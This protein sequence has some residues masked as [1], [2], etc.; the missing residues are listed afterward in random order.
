MDIND[1][2][3]NETILDELE[4]FIYVAD[5][6]TYEM[7]YMNKA[8]MDE[9]SC[10][11]YRG[12]KC[13]EV[14]HG[15]G[16]P[17][18]F[19]NS[20]RLI[21]GE[22]FSW[23]NYNATVGRT[24]QLQDK[25]IDYDGHHARMEI[26]I[27]V[28]RRIDENMKLKTV[29]ETEKLLTRMIQT[30]NRH[31][32]MD[33]RLDAMIREIGEYFN[34]DRSY[35]FDAV[36]G[37]D[38]F[39]NS[40]EWCREGI[41]PQITK[42]QAVSASCIDRW[43]YFFDNHQAV[44]ISDVESIIESKPEEYKIMTMQGIHS[45]LE[46]PIF[47]NDEFHGF[48]GID[49]PEPAKIKD[50]GSLMMSFAYAVSNAIT[51]EKNEQK[52]MNQATELEAIIKNLPIGVSMT[53]VRDGK[54][55]SK[56]LNPPL[57]VL[58]GITEDQVESAEQIAMS[59]VSEADRRE[60][61]ENMEKLRVPGMYVKSIFHYAL[62]DNDYRWYQMN[63]RSIMLDD[64]LVYFSCLFD[65]TV[66]KENEIKLQ[67]NQDM[68]REAISNSDVQFFTYY[69][70]KHLV[71]IPIVNERYGK[72]P[73]SMENCPDSFIKIMN[74][75][76]EHAKLMREMTR[77]MDDGE[78][79][80]SCQ[81]KVIYDGMPLWINIKLTAVR[82]EHGHTIMAQGNAIDIT[83]QKSAE[84]KLHQQMV[85]LQSLE[86]DTVEAFSFNV[87]KNAQVDL[88]TMDMKMMNIPVS[89][90]VIRDADEVAPAMGDP[91]AETRQILLH[92]ANRIPDR[93]ERIKYLMTCGGMGIR[94]AVKKGRYEAELKYRRYLGDV[95]R[96]VSTTF[97]VLPDPESGDLFAFFYTEDIN[98]E[99]IKEKMA[100]RVIG[101]NYLTVSAVDLQTGMVTIQTTGDELDSS[102]NGYLYEEAVE[103]VCRNGVLPE[104][105]DACR[106]KFALSAVI[107]G[108]EKSDVYTGYYTRNERREDLPGKPLR[109]MKN[110]LVYLDENKDVLIF[111][112]SDV[113]E[114][115]EQERETREKM[116]EALHAA[117]TANEAKSDF[118]SRMS[119]D[120]RTPLNGIIGMTYIAKGEH[121]PDR[122]SLCLDKIDMS[123]KFLLGL[124][125]DVLD[126]AK[127]DSG[128]I[129]LHPEPYLMSDF[130]TYLDSVIK[131][132]YEG[133]NQTFDVE[134]HPVDSVIPIVDILRYNQIMF[135]L[136]SNAVKYTPEGGKIS[137]KVF[138]ELIL[139]HK[140][141]IIAIIEDNGIGMSD[142]FLEVLF[143]EFTQENRNDI[144]GTRGSGLG[145]AIVK[146]MV[147]LMGGTIEV[148]SNPGRGTR[149]TVTI[150]FD[151]IE[152][153]QA[154]WQKTDGGY[155]VD[156]GIL[157]GR[158]VLIC[159]DHPM[160]QE[161]VKELLVE[162]G[163]IVEIAENGQKGIELFVASALNFYDLILMDIRMPILDG[164][165]TTRR[166]RAL[167][168]DD[169]KIVP[170][171][172]MTADAFKDDVEKCL[173]LGMNGH[174]AKPVDPDLLYET[175]VDAIK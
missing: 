25:L 26:A 106:K 172:A 148:D 142:D 81:I 69:P 111:M 28:S 42:R 144:S 146:S 125:N 152:A 43:K 20:D 63:A 133:K 135:N 141:R 175:M 61:K 36:N 158:H 104:E 97:Q 126:M 103:Q 48:F 72:L 74:M 87:T 2:R 59:R 56:V 1:L 170:I 88:Q 138:N 57:Q 39:N 38:V 6:D 60:V 117:E 123:S 105:A 91:Q 13:Y 127:V 94:K 54:A 160:N 162:K 169:A 116:A 154:T 129:E 46:A 44:I 5:V 118:L 67:E 40:F 22:T 164:Y 96:W 157:V 19:C 16:E 58:Y 168:R 35:I 132:L 140:E 21:K 47:I 55:I 139:G 113:T 122:T 75:S 110:D 101:A 83:V 29:L 30:L 86:G 156:Y 9:F 137:L 41:E 50:S 102:I 155:T 149:F 62:S 131:P 65:V 159:E 11:A 167:D 92:V 52:I 93:D 4:Q 33:Q 18:Q 128:K 150:D 37:G 85:R 12:K 95:I 99:V 7:L 51:K 71:T 17:C 161:I 8:A 120:I 82:D 53:T 165:E 68:L 89:E 27:D 119:H 90:E 45:Y 76:D 109:R 112:L 49:N 108:L 15:F 80:S 147:D 134:T 79:N 77:K 32:P 153:D 121:N 115:F 31:E 107:A 34:S 14:V 64:E 98:D 171:I 66:D 23:D 124:I 145:L 174:I 130:D 3:L 163:L 10:T 151:Y 73:Q 143:D 24:Y 173:K 84:E 136:L 70:D 166:I 78:D 100:K 114:I